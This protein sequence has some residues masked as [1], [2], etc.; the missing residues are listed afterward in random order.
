MTKVTANEEAE[1][2]KD[3]QQGFEYQDHGN[4][5]SIKGQELVDKSLRIIIKKGW[6]ANRVDRVLKM[7]PALA[8]DL[9]RRKGIWTKYRGIIRDV[10]AT[11]TFLNGLSFNESYLVST[12]GRRTVG[13]ALAIYI[14]HER[15]ELHKARLVNEVPAD[16]ITEAHREVLKEIDPRFGKL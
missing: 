2:I 6:Y 15:K 16:V 13:K 5:Y 12:D 1:F 11:N 8:K 3:M 4:S 9:T 14:R 10:Q 7:I